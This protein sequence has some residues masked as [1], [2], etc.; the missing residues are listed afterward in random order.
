MA[1]PLTT[2]IGYGKFF[3]CLHFWRVF[4]AKIVKF[5]LNVAYDLRP[6]ITG[7]ILTVP[8]SN[9]EQHV[10]FRGPCNITITK[11]VRSRLR[12][13]KLFSYVSASPEKLK[14]SQIFLI[15]QLL[16]GSNYNQLRAT[17]HLKKCRG[18]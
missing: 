17:I 2:L 3:F 6:C 11:N 9:R 5:I 7:L 13:L 14:S 10:S 1:T 4:D 18:K 16:T 15:Q 8:T 12:S